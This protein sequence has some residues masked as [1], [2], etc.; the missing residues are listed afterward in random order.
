MTFLFILFYKYIS[1]YFPDNVQK[2]MKDDVGIP[3]QECKIA[4]KQIFGPT[5]LC[6]SNSTVIFNERAIALLSQW[7]G[8]DKFHKYLKN[9]II[10]KIEK[11]VLKPVLEEGVIPMWTNNNAESLHNVMKNTTQWK[12]QQL[13]EL[14]LKMYSIVEFQRSELERAIIGTGEYAL[15][16]D[17]KKLLHISLNLDH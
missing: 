10:P 1:L 5:G 14:V 8:Y 2:Y 11:Y 4:A 16:N 7:I 9:R 15:A 6:Q 3:E 13:P 17:Y 12:I